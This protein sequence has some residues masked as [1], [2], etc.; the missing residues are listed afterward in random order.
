[1]TTSPG[2]L[3]DVVAVDPRA[4]PRWALLAAGPAGSLFASPPWISVL[5]EE[6]GFVPT[7]R[8]LVDESGEPSAGFTWI[9][10]SDL[11]GERISSL[12]FSERVEPFVQDRETWSRLA[13]DVLKSGVPFTMRCFEDSPVASHEG[14]D[15][16]GEAAWH[17]TPLDA[18]L[19]EI[20]AGFSPKARQMLRASERRGVRTR[21][22]TDLA[23]VREFHRLH[24]GLRKQK[25]GLLAQSVTFFERLWE[26]FASENG[27]LTVL[28]EDDGVPVAGAMYFVW[29][30]T[31]Y[32]KFG[33]SRPEHLRLRPNEAIAWAAMRWAKEHGIRLLD[34]GL[35]DLDQPG[36]LSFKRK[37]GGL[38]RTIVTLRHS[39]A[40]VR[41]SEEFQ[42]LLGE[43]TEL[44][45][46][47]AVP[48]D[49]AAR[50]GASLY[51]YFC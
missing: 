31:L 9:R 33:A 30:D 21:V 18:P 38:E 43:L 1:V 29:N 4:D 17:G 37:W 7:A 28:A 45:T 6:Y 50:A 10:I 2:A 49:V 3:Q 40:A 5:C 48:S 26:A 42:D 34:W 23:A 24:V 39:G 14:L 15:R 44:F 12:P 36:L 27:V 32:Y 51:R 16:I 47:D 46:D 35:S 25:Y 19:E 11:R 41:S 13:S 20:S 8:V 22:C